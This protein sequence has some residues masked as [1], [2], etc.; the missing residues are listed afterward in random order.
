MPQCAV[1]GWP[2]Q[3]GQTSC[4]ALSQTVKTKWSGGESGLE[5]SSYDLLRGFAVLN[6]AFSICFRASGRTCPVG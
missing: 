4:A 5:N 6:P 2:G 1:M 3:M